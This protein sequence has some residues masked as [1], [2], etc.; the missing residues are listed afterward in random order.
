MFRPG[1]T[2]DFPIMM[3][4]QVGHPGLLI[5]EHNI[6]SF[7]GLEYTLAH[8]PVTD[9]GLPYCVASSGEPYRHGTVVGTAIGRNSHAL[10]LFV[11]SS[12]ASY[13]R[14]G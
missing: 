11:R 13:E 2:D 1:S 7:V 3:E 12:C 14:G 9:S 5:E 4:E 6:S 8:S 10:K